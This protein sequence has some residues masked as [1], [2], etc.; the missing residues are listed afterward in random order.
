MALYVQFCLLKLVSTKLIKVEEKNNLK[1]YP[2]LGVGSRPFRGHL[3]PE[4]IDNF[5]EEYQGIST[6]TLQSAF[7]YDYPIDQVKASIRKINQKLPNGDC[8]IIDQ[9]EQKIL[10]GIL[11][12]CRSEY[13]KVIEMLAPFINSISMY[14]PQRRARKLHIGL[15]G[16][17]RCVS[18][19]HLPRAISFASSLYTIGLPP[20]FI[21]M[22]SLMNLHE[23][24][25]R[26]LQKYYVHM[27]SD[28]KSI[29]Q[30]FSWKNINFLKE[31]SEK[32]SKKANL[33]KEKFEYCSFKNFNRYTNSGKI[34]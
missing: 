14:V 13:E 12:K 3:S 20:E 8:A 6:V 24:E 28:L 21:G 31:V 4:N 32:I 25:W 15:F 10:I 5:L 22:K 26:V 19:I 33:S 2:I 23:N 17:S 27:E 30:Y 9:Q 11:Q 29:G 18:G 7:R 1:I 34:F 16:Y